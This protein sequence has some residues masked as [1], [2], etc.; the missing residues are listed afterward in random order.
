MTTFSTIETLALKLPESQR[1]VLAARIL[2]SLPAL[3]QE[4]DEGL[5]EAKKRDAELDRCPA[6]ALSLEEFDAKIHGRRAQ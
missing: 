6:L 3:F 5:A 1:A 2:D 4:N